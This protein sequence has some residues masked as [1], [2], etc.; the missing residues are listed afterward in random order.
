MPSN[1]VNPA[2]TPNTPNTPADDSGR[3]TQVAAIRAE[4]DESHEE[5]SDEED[6]PYWS[7][8]KEDSSQPDEQELDLIE[9]AS[10]EVNALD[11][12]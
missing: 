5:D 3:D 6:V 1:G 11:R 8:F 10:S 9:Q 2:I 12:A 7:N 4:E